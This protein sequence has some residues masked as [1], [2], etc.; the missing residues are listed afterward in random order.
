[1][2][3]NL[4]FTKK[5]T[6]GFKLELTLEYTQGFTLKVNTFQHFQTLLEYFLSLHLFLK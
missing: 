2:E 3:I 6:L 4:G 1:M 5:I